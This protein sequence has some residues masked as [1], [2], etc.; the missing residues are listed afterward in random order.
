MGTECAK[1]HRCLLFFN[2]WQI[3]GR[4]HFLSLIFFIKFIAV[5][6][7]MCHEDATLILYIHC[8]SKHL[9]KQLHEWSVSTGLIVL[10]FFWDGVTV[11]AALLS[12]IMQCYNYNVHD[13]EFKI[14]MR[15]SCCKS[16]WSVHYYKACVGS[17]VSEHNVH[18]NT[19][20]Y[21]YHR[22]L[23]IHTVSKR[24]SLIWETHFHIRIWHSTVYI[25]VKTKILEVL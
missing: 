9:C 24:N 5:F 19:P 13:G 18:S 2:T 1:Y 10:G 11:V 12:F 16:M 15:T 20:W 17:K 6:K 23:I 22:E 25:T 7:E 21:L 3:T 8:T 14:L 4:S